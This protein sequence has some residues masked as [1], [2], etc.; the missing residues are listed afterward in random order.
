MHPGEV[1]RLLK[2]QVGLAF[3]SIQNEKDKDVR[4]EHVRFI[5]N[6]KAKI[7]EIEAMP[8]AERRAAIKAEREKRR[9]KKVNAVVSPHTPIYEPSVSSTI[10]EMAQLRA[11]RK[12]HGNQ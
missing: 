12:N 9:A 4:I 6:A 1:K 3:S 8:K 10:A 7:A 2:Y 5:K 11:G